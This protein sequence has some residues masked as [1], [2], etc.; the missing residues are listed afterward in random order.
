MVGQILLENGL[1]GE[2]LEDGGGV[3]LLESLS[4]TDNINLFISNINI[5]SS[6]IDLFINSPIPI[7]SNYNLFVNGFNTQSNNIDLFLYGKN[8]EFQNQILFIDGYDKQIEN[9]DLS[10]YGLEQ[11]NNFADLIVTGNEINNNQ[12]ELFINGL[13]F[14]NKYINLFISSLNV[15][16]N[17]VDLFINGPVLISNDLNLTIH[18]F[19]INFGQADL[20]CDGYDVVYN[21]INLLI[22]GF[23]YYESDTLELFL[24]GKS[25]KAQDI[26]FF[27]SGPVYIN[28]YLDLYLKT[29][30]AK[31]LDLFVHGSQPPPQISCPTLDP[32]ASIQISDDLIQI[33]QSRIDALINQLGKNVLLIFDPIIESCPNCTQDIISH[34]STG[35]YKLGGPIPFP[36]GQK[37]NYCK[38]VGFLE[39]ENAKCLK[40]LIKWNPKEL[41]NYGISVQKNNGIVRLKTFLT[42]APDLIKCKYAIVNHDIENIFKLKVKLVSGPVP[43]GLREDRYCI[44]YFQLIDL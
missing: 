30:N 5:V 41:S 37:C 35:I 44:A 10:I 8:I 14:K 11:K 15:L 3:L 16:G 28:E 22:Y 24:H 21:Q 32:T 18:G 2:L 6:F 38:G 1:D 39:R 43:V 31:Q 12:L 34:R 19:D 42:S 7:N 23:E 20:F 36:R 33:Y 13:D 29:K 25:A 9:I 17:I 4:L 27:I 40:C 26:N